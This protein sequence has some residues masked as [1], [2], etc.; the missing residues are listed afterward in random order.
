MYKFFFGFKEN[1]FKLVPN[2]AFLFLSKSHEEALAHLTYAVAQG[3]GFMEITGEVGTGKTTLCR[4]FLENLDPHASAAYIFNPN[5]NSLQLLKAINDEFGI[6]SNADNIK[7]L[8][9]TLNSFLIEQKAKD[10]KTI[11]LIDEA[12]N[13][14]NEV[15]EQL[16]LLSNLETT[17]DKLIHII[18]VGQPELKEKLNS[19]ELRQLEQ[20]ISLSC[21]LIPLN[22]KEVRDYIQHRIRIASEKTDIRFDPAA[23]RSIYTYSRG[24]PRLINIVCD[25]ALLTAFGLDQQKITKDVVGSAIK[26]LTNREDI[27]DNVFTK[28]KK[29]ILPFFVLSILSV[30][31]I[32]YRSGFFGKHAMLNSSGVKNPHARSSG[33]SSYPVPADKTPKLN[34]PASADIVSDSKKPAS[35]DILP[36]PQKTASANITL[37]PQ[38]PASTDITLGPQKPASTDILDDSKKPASADTAPGPQKTAS[39]AAPFYPKEDEGEKIKTSVP[40]TKPSQQPVRNLANILK[41]MNR[42]SSRHAALGIALKLW[43][44]EPVIKPNLDAIDDDQA[45]FQRAAK[46]NGLLMRRIEGSL[47]AIKKLNLPAILSIDSSKDKT[48]RYLA[49]IK[50][51]IQQITLRGGKQ[52]ISIELTPA[53]LESYWSGTAYIPWKNFLSIT[54]TIPIDSSKDSILTLKKLLRDIG[55]KKVELTPFYDDQTR[56][57]V[58][59]IQRKYGL[60]IDGAVGSTTKI[61][62][63][64]EKKSLKRPYIASDTQPVV[65]LQ[66]KK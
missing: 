12:Q 53:E 3:E 62:L 48:P 32:F 27:D 59:K 34:K 44:L 25:R 28:W 42:L 46:E 61:A 10:K 6:A 24:I 49:L 22:V 55:F 33:Y 23:Y 63:Y 20:R 1:P 37:G 41:T 35:T 43:D 38:K 4:A 47:N 29:A 51:D 21:R 8:I 50:T 56:E 57:A 40:E 2:P 45:F 52:D 19:Y 13:L 14:T 60:R 17:R 7:D 66:N 15:L 11:L 5:L 54:G 36:N 9:D 16:R 39:I 18:L 30:L 31:L 64:N 58:E 26:E 65:R